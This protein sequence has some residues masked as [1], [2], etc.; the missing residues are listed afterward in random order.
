MSVGNLWRNLN[1]FVSTVCK[2]EENFQ[3][4]KIRVVGYFFFLF[5]IQSWEAV[6]E[7]GEEGTRARVILNVYNGIN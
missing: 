6:K 3:I 7:T 1:D 2:Q 5:L 4:F